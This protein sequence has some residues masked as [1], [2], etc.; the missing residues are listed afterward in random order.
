MQ[1]NT[2]IVSLVNNQKKFAK[3][4]LEVDYLIIVNPCYEKNLYEEEQT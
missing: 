2:P 3:I 4:S 1:A